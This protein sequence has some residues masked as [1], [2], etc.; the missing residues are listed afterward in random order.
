MRA[1]VDCLELRLGQRIGRPP[2]KE[3]AS[4]V[5]VGAGACFQE[6]RAFGILYTSGVGLL[7]SAE[8]QEWLGGRG[9]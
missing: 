2:W 1:G 9:G 5:D 3:A 6:W 8:H 7:R 4:G